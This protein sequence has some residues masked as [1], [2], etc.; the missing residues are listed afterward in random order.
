[1]SLEF[2]VVSKKVILPASHYWSKSLFKAYAGN[3]EMW[4][5]LVKLDLD[6]ILRLNKI[7]RPEPFGSGL[8]KP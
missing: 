5:H 1:M 2:V 7:N 6:W 4:V 8:K 3:I